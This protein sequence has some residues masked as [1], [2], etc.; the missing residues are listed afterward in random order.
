MR[1]GGSSRGK[2]SSKPAPASQP[3]PASTAK[4]VKAAK[5]KAKAKG[6]SASPGAT[7]VSGGGGD[8]REEAGVDYVNHT[9][10]A[11]ISLSLASPKL[12][13][14]EIVERVAAATMVRW[15]QGSSHA[16]RGGAAATMI[17]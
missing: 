15:V 5:G 13:M 1:A 17:R 3:A 9:C 12:L 11:C 16:W 14:L 2:S 6:A 7:L 4:E 10:S 8:G